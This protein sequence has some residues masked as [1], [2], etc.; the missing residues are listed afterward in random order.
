M[1]PLT[2]IFYEAAWT[3]NN[4]QMTICVWIMGCR[5]TN[6]EGYLLK[7]RRDRQRV[8]QCNRFLGPLPPRQPKMPWNL[9]IWTSTFGRADRSQNKGPTNVETTLQS[10]YAWKQT[11][12]RSTASVK[13][14]SIQFDEEICPT[15]DLPYID[16]DG[17][18][19]EQL[20]YVPCPSQWTFFTYMCY[21]PD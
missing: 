9:E 4:F 13:T 5:S 19:H 15:I 17:P 1:K 21:Q 3:L 18:S 2:E 10:L 11:F 6:L 7:D 8:L 16:G 20:E 14:R 12:P